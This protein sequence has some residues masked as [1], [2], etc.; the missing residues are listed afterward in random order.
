MRG[1]LSALFLI[2]CGAIWLVWHP[3]WQPFFD[4]VF[5]LILFIILGKLVL[6]PTFYLSALLK[7][8]KIFLFGISIMLSV[9]IR[10]M[11]ALLTSFRVA[12]HFPVVEYGW[13][14]PYSLVCAAV[15]FIILLN[16]PYVQELLRAAT[17]RS[18]EVS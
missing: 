17:E 18:D 9:F 10:W 4:F 13:G 16:I 7:N 11:I 8:G 12:K 14:I 15:V 3:G 1:L 6:V 5:Q 2:I